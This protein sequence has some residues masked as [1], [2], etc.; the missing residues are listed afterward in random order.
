MKTGL[1]HRVAVSVV[2]CF[3]AAGLAGCG[4]GKSSAKSDA[5]ELERAF[6]LKAGDAPSQES[7]PAGVASR[8]VAAIRAQDWPRALS[9]LNWMR[10]YASLTSDQARAVQS[11]YVNA[12]LRLS[13]LAATGNA[14]A[15]AALDRAKQQVDRR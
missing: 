2:A 12:H 8:A 7:T 14:E 11:A 5:T 3:L 13:E 4:G 9:L 6:G 15:K 10:M 1:K